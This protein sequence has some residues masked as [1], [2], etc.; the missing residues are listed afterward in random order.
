[1]LGPFATASRRTLPVLHCHSLG[2]ATVARRLRIDVHN[3]EDNDDNDNNDNAWQRGPL[4]RH[5]MSQKKKR[6]VKHI[7]RSASLPGGLK[8]KTKGI[9]RK[10]LRYSSCTTLHGALCQTAACRDSEVGVHWITLFGCSDRERVSTERWYIIRRRWQLSWLHCLR[11]RHSVPL[12]LFLKS[13][14]QPSTSL[15]RLWSSQH[16]PS[17][18]YNSVGPHCVRYKCMYAR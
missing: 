16:L 4:W 10:S 8:N 17:P 1:M 9:R 15:L 3:N 7:A 14:L 11:R 6:K 13:R 5:R 2:V 12:Q 18:R